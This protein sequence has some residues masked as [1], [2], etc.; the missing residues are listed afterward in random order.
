VCGA[1]AER[2]EG[3]RGRLGKQNKEVKKT[4]PYR[5]ERGEGGIKATADNERKVTRMGTCREEVSTIAR[6]AR[7]SL[8]LGGRERFSSEGK[9]KEKRITGQAAETQPR[10]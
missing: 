3:S 9:K 6:I 1:S 5:H 8:A 2:G 4:A 10:V 7:N